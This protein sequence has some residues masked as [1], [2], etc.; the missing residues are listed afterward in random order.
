M[1][2]SNEISGTIISLAFI[3]DRK[4]LTI[5]L[6]KAIPQTNASKLSC[7][8]I[9]QV[10][11]PRLSRLTSLLSF[12][13]ARIDIEQVSFSFHAPAPLPCYK[14]SSVDL[15]L[16]IPFVLWGCVGEAIY[17]FTRNFSERNTI[18]ASKFVTIE[19]FLSLDSAESLGNF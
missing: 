4:E 17:T 9:A 19:P 10:S 16:F 7:E 1:R 15:A 12:P 3:P 2:T 18:S 11:F 5:S 13:G 14:C 6:V 8:P